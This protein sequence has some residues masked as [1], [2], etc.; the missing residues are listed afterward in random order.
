MIWAHAEFVACGV[1]EFA[2]DTTL[3]VSLPLPLFLSFSLLRQTVAHFQLYGILLFFMI[4]YKTSGS[5][6]GSRVW[7]RRGG[8]STGGR[9]VG[10]MLKQ[11]AFVW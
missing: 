2:G 10:H 8:V 11:S 6:R 3:F 5:K 1:N 4:V 7:G 9:S